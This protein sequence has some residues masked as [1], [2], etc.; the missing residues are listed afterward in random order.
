MSH[1]DDLVRSFGMSGFLVTDDIARIEKKH[2]IALGHMNSANSS[3]VAEKLKLFEQR[4]QNE[5]AEMAVYYQLFYCLEKSIRDLISENLREKASENW[6]ESERVPPAIK[7]EVN[8]RKQT[9]I[10]SGVTIRSD[11]PLDYTTFGE[12]EGI[13]TKNWDV[14]GVIFESQR[15]VQKIMKNLNVLRGPIAHCCPFS[16]D[17]KER[18]KITVND[19]FRQL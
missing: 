10:D 17:E 19:W 3:P 11:K 12:L 6:W 2:A 15:A 13:I 16:E 14:F 5:A 4:T 9:E 7:E 1:F 8:K 18:L